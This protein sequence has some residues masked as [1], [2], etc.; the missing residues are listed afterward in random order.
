MPCLILFIHV[1]CFRIVSNVTELNLDGGS[2]LMKSRAMWTQVVT[3]EAR[4]QHQRTLCQWLYM[5][6]Y[7]LQHFWTSVAGNNEKFVYT[8][9]CA[10]SS[11]NTVIRS[12]LCRWVRLKW[13]ANWEPLASLWSHQWQ[14]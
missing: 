6:R 3:G 14:G 4:V 8:V 10:H 5:V 9:Y 12:I 13:G 1:S 2:R 7:P 11:H